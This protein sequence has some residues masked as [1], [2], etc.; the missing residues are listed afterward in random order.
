MT[1][2][3]LFLYWMFVTWDVPVKKV[4][5]SLLWRHFGQDEEL[6]NRKLR[7]ESSP[8]PRNPHITRWRYIEYQLVYEKHSCKYSSVSLDETYA[9]NKLQVR[10]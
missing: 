10:V 3:W 2:V 6:R 9:S 7:G 1:A 4:N 8:S 5:T